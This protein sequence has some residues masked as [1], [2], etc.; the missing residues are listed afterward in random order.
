MSSNQSNEE[1]IDITCEKCGREMSIPR[2]NKKIRV[3]CP[4]TDCRHE[5]DYQYVE[6]NF[7]N[8]VESK[9]QSENIC[10]LCKRGYPEFK[11]I[12]S[13][14]ED[15]TKIISGT[16]RAW[17]SND[18]GG[19]W[20]DVPVTGTQRSERDTQLAPPDHPTQPTI[21]CLTLG[22]IS[23]CVLVA[24]PVIGIICATSVVNYFPEI[25]SEVWSFTN[26]LGYATPVIPLIIYLI[27]VVASKAKF[28]AAVSKWN[29]E[30]K[31]WKRLNYCDYD[32]K[33]YDPETQR[34]FDVSA[35]KDYIAT[36]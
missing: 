13:H 14:V 10:P 17:V 30:M 24:V 2:R 9:R 8:V 29:Q 16:S 36:R 12:E 4:Y 3:R 11:T 15:G 7:D 28:A 23:L 32:R 31:V 21:T 18:Y 6:R 35:L 1:K 27:W 25:S 5:F 19:Q 34:V 22:L 26:I 20:V 33:I